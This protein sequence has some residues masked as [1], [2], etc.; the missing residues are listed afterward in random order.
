MQL[1]TV[2]QFIRTT[3]LPKVL[4][5]LPA[6]IGVV[7]ISNQTISPNISYSIASIPSPT[8][9]IASPTPFRP[10]EVP[11]VVVSTSTQP[12]L[13]VNE[14]GAT[15]SYTP[16]QRDFFLYVPKLNIQVPI[17][18]N[19]SGDDKPGY[20]KALENGVAHYAGT[21]LPG[22]VGRIFVFGHSS[23][24][25]NLPGNYK[26]IFAPLNKLANGDLMYV[27]YQGG[28]FTYSVIGKQIVAADDVSV[29][30]QTSSKILT[31]QTCWPIG[32]SEKRLIVNG[33]QVNS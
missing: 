19:V 10:T 9:V 18:P 25:R 8:P 27:Y 1:H 16:P 21:S 2:W 3:L 26:S 31:L 17:I 13:V 4:Y 12:Q 6:I 32:T 24:Y 20:L 23:Y 11:T 22:E 15:Q 30:S 28:Q 29:L 14:Q 7:I 33:E 5:Y